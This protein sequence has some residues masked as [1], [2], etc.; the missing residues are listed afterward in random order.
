MN[1]SVFRILEAVEHSDHGEL[2]AWL[3]SHPRMTLNDEE[4]E[5]YKLI[6]AARQYKYN[7]ARLVLDRASVK[8]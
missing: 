6:E 2:I 5:T 4:N 7:N 1:R 8:P 3:Q